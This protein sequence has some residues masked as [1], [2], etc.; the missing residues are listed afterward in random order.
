MFSV[1]VCV[2]TMWDWIVREYLDARR[3]P[4]SHDLWLLINTV[5]WEILTWPISLSLSPSLWLNS[6]HSDFIYTRA[7]DVGYGSKT[8][9]MREWLS[10]FLPSHA[11]CPLQAQHYG[12]T[13]EPAD[14]PEQPA[15]WGW[16]P[17]HSSLS[18]ER[19]RDEQEKSCDLRFNIW[20]F[21]SGGWLHHIALRVFTWNFSPD[22]HR[23]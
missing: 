15:V 6:I 12:K 4:W 18:T 2:C 3:I 10:P 23:Y 8:P 13:S 16:V 20:R 21:W 11:L 5:W 1:H 19:Q 14:C 22:R 17:S 9:V 7:F